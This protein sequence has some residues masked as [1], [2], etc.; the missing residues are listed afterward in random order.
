[1]IVDRWWLQDLGGQAVLDRASRRFGIEARAFHAETAAQLRRE[2]DTPAAR[3]M[4]AWFV[5]NTALP[6]EDAA[7]LLASEIARKPAMF[8][9]GNFV[10]G[11]GLMAYEPV[12]S[13]DEA[14]ALFAKLSGLVLD[15]MPPADIPIERPKA[16]RLSLNAAA[17][18]RMGT[19]LP[20]ALVKRADRVL[21]GDG[22]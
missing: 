6:F 15:G 8:P 17:A 19:E 12:F 10:D 1:V 9:T 20:V 4:D 2:L 22:H 3:S 7:A 14:L 18:R 11:G 16:F 21:P 5:P 13:I